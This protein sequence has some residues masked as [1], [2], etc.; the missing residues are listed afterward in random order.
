MSVIV[1]Y[2]LREAVRRKVFVVVLL[3]TTLFLA[4]YALANH[5]VFRDVATIHVPAN[6]ASLSSLVSLTTSPSS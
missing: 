2:A 1:G 6:L 4:L 3:L 5:Y